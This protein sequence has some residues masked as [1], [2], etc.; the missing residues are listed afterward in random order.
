[1]T[2]SNSS[3]EGISTMA[4]TLRWP[5]TFYILRTLNFALAAFVGKDKKLAI[6]STHVRMPN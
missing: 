5:A 4:I 1:M 6:Y 2:L 3:A